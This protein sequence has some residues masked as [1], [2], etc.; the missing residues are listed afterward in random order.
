MNYYKVE[1]YNYE[2]CFSVFITITACG[3][4]DAKQIAKYLLEQMWREPDDWTIDS[5]RE[6]KNFEK[7]LDKPIR[8]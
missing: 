7:T 5:I 6:E 8:M 1:M 4:N 3:P 2:K